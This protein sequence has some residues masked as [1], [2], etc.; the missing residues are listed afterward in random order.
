[1]SAVLP[2]S[3]SQMPSS[4]L[5]RALTQANLLT[6]AQVDIVNKKAQADKSGFID[7]LTQS[8]T[9]SARDLATFCSDAFGYPL[10][11]LSLIN[12]SQIPEKL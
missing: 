6:P 11:D 9:V 1:M 7:A 2:N 12:E 3:A 8:G 10:L 5:A 4:G